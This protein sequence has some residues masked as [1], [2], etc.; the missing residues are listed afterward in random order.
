MKKALYI[1]ALPL[2]LFIV[3]SFSN[4]TPLFPQPSA[5]VL[6]LPDSSI[7]APEAVHREK[8]RVVAGIINFNHYSK[9]ELNDEVSSQMFDSY[10]DNLDNTRSYFTAQDIER[11]EQYRYELDNNLLKG[12]LQIAYDIFNLYKQRVLERYE[13]NLEAL[14][15]NY[16]FDK[17][18][19]LEADR[20]NAPWVSSEQELNELW[21]KRIKN[22]LLT[23]VLTEKTLDESREIVKTRYERIVKSMH[24]T[25]NEDV[26][27]IFMNAL[28]NTYDPHT[29][30]FSPVK[31]QNFNMEINRSFE[32]IGA[33]L[34]NENDYTVI[35]EILP[36]GPAFKG[37]ELK[38]K[39]KI[40]GVAQGDQGEFV[41]VIGWRLDDVVSLIRG[42]KGTVVR[43]QV[44]PGDAAPNA[45]PK[46]IRLV[47]DKIK[48]EEQSASKKIIDLQQ[49]GKSYKLGVITVPSFYLNFEEYRSGKPDYK[50]TSNDVKKL[51][52]ELASENIDGL[53]VDLR[54]N[55]GGALQEAVD[56]TGLFIKKGPVVQIK[57][58]NGKINTVEDDDATKQYKGPLMVM[59]NAFSAS[60]SEIFAGA[61]QDY[62]RGVVVGEQTYGKGTVQSPIDLGQYIQDKDELMGQ[63]N[64]T[65]SKYYRAAGSSTQNK[66]V[67]PDIQL[68][69]LYDKE[70]IGESSQ[71]S[72]LPWDE[73]KPARFAPENDVNSTLIQK[74]QNSYQ[75]RLKTDA[76]LK[77]LIANIEEVKKLREDTKISLQKAE[78]EQEV[79]AYEKRREEREELFAQEAEGDKSLAEVKDP[80]LKNALNIMIEM[81][82]NQ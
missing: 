65:L 76:D 68:P 58:S 31:S 20:E 22:D 44:I 42:A 46:V 60:A 33:R 15:Q 19:Y 14:N 62:K 54:Y 49:D 3:W 45:K 5:I 4:G 13:Q 63:L 61:I 78:R 40:V 23:L 37:K 57:N 69:A 71:P 52:E 2:L 59:V 51:L 12:D 28:S 7:L 36:G 82:N 81:V 53:V 32:G 18:E 21:R 75:K 8:A 70:E 6:N 43:L 9:Q 10:L 16:D 79:E 35:Y 80:Y 27:E 66:G 50:S 73:I 39:D 41:D 56:L 47:R 1:L 26:F 72:A 38:P 30:Y 24:Q 48:I 55:G 74:L 11:F 34:Q 67:I 77:K 17:K 29:T 25:S 64:L